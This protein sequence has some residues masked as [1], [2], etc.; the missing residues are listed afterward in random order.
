MKTF[1]LKICF[2]VLLLCWGSTSLVAAAPSASDALA[3]LSFITYENTKYNFQINYPVKWNT[4]EGYLGTAVY[5]SS[6]LENSTDQFSENANVFVSELPA[7]S[8]LTIDKYTELALALLAKSVTNFKLSKQE[9]HISSGIPSKVV[10]FT[11]RQGI[12]KLKFIQKYILTK[13]KAYVITFTAEE[14]KYSAYE[15]IATLILSS[16]TIR[17]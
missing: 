8:N 2:S 15:E 4:G 14:E 6:P 3:N 10:T 16:I 5:F 9:N 7:N 13:N 1:L 11:G 12:F 17:F